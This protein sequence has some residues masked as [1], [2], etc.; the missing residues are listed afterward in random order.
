MVLMVM[1][2]AMFCAMAETHTIVL[3]SRVELEMPSFMLRNTE[4][5]EM[6]ETVVYS[7]SEITEGNVSTGFEIVQANDSNYRGQVRFTVEATELMAKV[8]GRV[9]ST[10][11]VQVVMNGTECGSS[12]EF[13]RAFMGAT[14]AAGSVVNSFEVI[15]NANAELP[16]TTYQAAV[17]LTYTAA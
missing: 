5:G 12:A 8:N 15:W 13:T 10:E 7:T 11:G 17:T 9:Y 1:A 4:T 6:G 3:V 16:Q 14:R 2:I